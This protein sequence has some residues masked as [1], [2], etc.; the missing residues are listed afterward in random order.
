MKESN[1]NVEKL[2]YIE[3]YNMYL[4]RYYIEKYRKQALSVKRTIDGIVACAPLFFLTLVMICDSLRHIWIIL[5]S[6]SSVIEVFCRYLPYQSKQEELQNCA[7]KMDALIGKAK[8]CWDRYKLGL[9][10][11]AEF[12][13]QYEMLYATY[14][15]I[16]STVTTE[17]YKDNPRYKDYAMKKANERLL[18]ITDYKIVNLLKEIRNKGDASD[19]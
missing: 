12:Q 2:F 7:V 11:M 15:K 14:I 9:M 5:A 10:Q 8:H 16:S 19:E 6:I 4:Y 17:A 1:N 18:E 3:Y 13:T